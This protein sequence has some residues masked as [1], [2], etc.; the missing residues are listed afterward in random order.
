MQMEGDQR[1]IGH[2]LGALEM[3]ECPAT[4]GMHHA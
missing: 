1:Q 2:I 4:T 3:P